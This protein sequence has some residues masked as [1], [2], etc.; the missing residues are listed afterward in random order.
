MAT[1]S[2]IAM[3]VP[4]GVRAVY[5]HWDGYPE[6]VGQTLQD[7]YSEAIKVAELLEKG[8]ISGLNS[9]LETS[10]F[11][12]DRGEELKVNTFKST[13]EW[14]DWAE[15]CGCEFAYLY[16]GVAWKHEAI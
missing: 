1:R 15:R 5:C 14:I 4:D 16:D 3:S 8:D 6:G 9:T 2:T 10:V 7:H 11:Y 12:V 13:S